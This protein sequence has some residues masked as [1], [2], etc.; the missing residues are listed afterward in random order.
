MNFRKVIPIKQQSLWGKTILHRSTKKVFRKNE[1]ESMAGLKRIMG[2]FILILFFCVVNVFA[3]EGYLRITSIPESASVEIS[4]KTIGKTPILTVLKPGKYTYKLTLTGYETVSG[5]AEIVENEV[6]VINIT[7]TKQVQKAPVPKKTEVAKG[8]I[9][10]ITDWQ[11]VTV[12]LNG[13]KIDKVPPVTIKDVPAGL[14]KVI[15]VSGDY[16]DSFHV[17]VQPGKT[18]VLKK[19]F[20]EDRKKY[21]LGLAESEA[22]KT[23]TPIEVKTSKLPA[24]MVVR[25]I[26]TVSADSKKQDV[27]ILGES[28]VIEVLLQYRKAGETDW[29]TKTFQSGTKTEDMFEIEKGSYEIQI[30]A[31]HYKVPTGLLNVLLTKKEKVREYKESLKKD[32]QPDVQYTFTVSY[33]GKD[34][35][36]K[37]EEAKLNTPVK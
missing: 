33:D 20:E 37:L 36:Y 5:T 9:T 10:I 4:G 13:H 6:T 16:A 34:F 12:F 14:N 7:L 3:Q 18:S 19:N 21:E 32:V 24:K 23:E 28:D 17:F 11:D 27:P 8:K 2:L 26:T 15:L 1:E 35:S 30:I 22:V 31:S 29:N 25:L